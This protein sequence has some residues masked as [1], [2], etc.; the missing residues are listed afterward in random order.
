MVEAAVAAFDVKFG[1]R[2]RNED[3]GFE[4]SEGRRAGCDDC[5]INQT[6]RDEVREFM[7]QHITGIARAYGDERER[8][9]ANAAVDY[10]ISKADKT[11][12]AIEQGEQDP[13]DGSFYTVYCGYVESARDARTSQA[14]DTSKSTEEV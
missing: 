4:V 14:E 2:A 11:E 5:E 12:N 10:I 7:A 1:K 13:L 6:W 3:G 9:G 8:R